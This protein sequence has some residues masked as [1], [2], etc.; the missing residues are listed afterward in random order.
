MQNI[1]HTSIAPEST[2]FKCFT[3]FLKE[4]KDLYCNFSPDQDPLDMAVLLSVI[5]DIDQT[6]P[7]LGVHYQNIDSALANVRKIPSS[8][9]ALA[10]SKSQGTLKQ[11]KTCIEIM[12]SNYLFLRLN[13]LSAIK[14]SEKKYFEFM[15]HPHP[16]ELL[17]F[18]MNSNMNN[19]QEEHI[20]GLAMQILTRYCQ[21]QENKA[22]A[23]ANED[24]DSALKI[25]AVEREI[26]SSYTDKHSHQFELISSISQHKNKR[27]DK[28]ESHFRAA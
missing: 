9:K 8:S 15:D 16:L 22:Q 7:G 11:E 12:L 28:I 20:Q 24:V 6:L 13:I 18:F 1:N 3:S 26:V 19:A 4:L 25:I 23:I 14:L 17:N 5:K 27:L 10:V 2:H 21:E